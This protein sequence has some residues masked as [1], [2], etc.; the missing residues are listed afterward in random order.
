MGPDWVEE[1]WEVGDRKIH[2]VKVGGGSG[3]KEV[4]RI[5]QQFLSVA[6]ARVSFTHDI[7]Q[8]YLL[9]DFLKINIDL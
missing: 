2:W 4:I 6:I 8:A 1:D 5:Q 7:N 3:W 9:K